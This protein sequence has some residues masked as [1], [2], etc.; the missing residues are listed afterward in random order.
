MHQNRNIKHAIKFAATS[1]VIQSDFGLCSTEVAYC[2]CKHV[3]KYAAYIYVWNHVI[4][5]LKNIQAM[6][7]PSRPQFSLWNLQPTWVREQ[8]IAALGFLWLHLVEDV[9]DIKYARI[10]LGIFFVGFW[11]FCCVHASF[12]CLA[13]T[14]FFP[15]DGS[16]GVS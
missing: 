5:K 2:Q 13:R 16:K 15:K 12:S 11:I 1:A 6:T 14:F 8:V 3:P 9:L 4:C 10:F 7:N